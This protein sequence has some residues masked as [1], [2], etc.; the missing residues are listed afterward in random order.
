MLIVPTL[1]AHLYFAYRQSTTKRPYNVEN[2][3]SELI[4]IGL[5]VLALSFISDLLEIVKA[6]A[7][8][9]M[10]AQLVGVYAFLNYGLFMLVQYKRLSEIHEN[11][12][13]IRMKWRI[14]FVILT[15]A[16]SSYLFHLSLTN[17][18]WYIYLFGVCIFFMDLVFRVKW[19]A[20]INYRTK[21]LSIFFLSILALILAGITQNLIAYDLPYVLVETPIHNLF[22]IIILGFL[23]LYT[24]ISFILLLSNMPIASV[25]ERRSEEIKSF[26]EINQSIISKQPSEETFQLLFKKCFS[27]TDADVGWLITGPFDNIN[28]TIFHTDDID[29]TEVAFYQQGIRLKELV[30]ASNQKRY[31]PNLGDSP[32]FSKKTPYQ[33]LLVIPIPS[34][35]EYPAVI[36]LLKSIQEGFDEYQIQLA[37]SYV[38]QAKLA[39]ENEALLRAN[40]ESERLKQELSIARRIQKGLLPQ[41]FPVSDYFELIGFSESAYEVGGDY[42]DFSLLDEEH[43]AL[44]IADVSGSGTSAAFYMANLHGIFQSLVQMNLEVTRFLELANVAMSTCLEKTAF[45]TAT[46]SVLDFEKNVLT[47]SRAGHTP[48]LYYSQE[49]DEAQYLEDEG[50]GLGII[51]NKSYTKFVKGYEQAF[52]SGDIF[53]FNTDGIGEARNPETG[54]PYGTERMR[55]CVLNHADTSATM[56]KKLILQNFRDYA[57]GNAS[58]DDRTLIVVKIK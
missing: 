14:V 56:L 41:K 26:R 17:W 55:Q 53:V 1:W 46:Y 30:A 37:E 24:L 10:L 45:V 28:D 29:K 31:F 50:M 16:C 48:I 20:F 9:I 32:P 15:I 49:L 4:Q 52:S 19:I 51:R 42:C 13:S 44:I 39:F 21:W 35:T 25:T 7:W 33:S 27:D 3:F 6:P 18:V 57:K 54:E 12:S 34:P 8:S 47:Y 43:L 58:K 36:C 22:F 38:N 5:A 40:V 2:L 23:G 11:P